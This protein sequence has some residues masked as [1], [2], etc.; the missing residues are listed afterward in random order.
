[1][2]PFSLNSFLFIK[3][4]NSYLSDKNKKVLLRG[5]LFATEPVCALLTA[6][7]SFALYYSAGGK[8]KQFPFWKNEEVI[9]FFSGRKSILFDGKLRSK[10]PRAS[11]GARK[12]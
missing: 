8:K 3:S 6:L 1:M 2:P 7:G 4:K 5:T 9:H 11:E 10:R 12:N